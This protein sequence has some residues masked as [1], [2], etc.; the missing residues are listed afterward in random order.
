MRKKG[1]D[2]PMAHA[3]SYYW[4]EVRSWRIQHIVEQVK[5][6]KV[7]G[8]MLDYIRYPDQ[9][10]G[11]E[12]AMV[13]AYHR[14]TGR[15]IDNL[16]PGDRDWLMFRAE[17]I[18]LFIRQLRQELTK[19][20]KP[21]ILSAFVGPDPDSDLRR[22]V[23]CWPDWVQEGLLDMICLGEY[24]RN[25]SDFYN[26]V[27]A[28]RKNSPRPIRISIVIACWGGN[29]NNRQLLMKGAE[30]ALAAG[31]DEIAIYR[32]DAIDLLD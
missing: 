8:L 24:S 26:S 17:Y 19:L 5:E 16:D 18:T 13:E 12:P 3:L 1:S 25:F 22:V 2:E 10:C 23:R 4:P 29:L 14:T 30:V 7:D 20:D 32:G 6:A 9:F 31:P 21:V 27:I 11:Y 28:A 15:E